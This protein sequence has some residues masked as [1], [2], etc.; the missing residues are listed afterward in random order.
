M[1]KIISLAALTAL[2]AACTETM[3]P[4][5]E[6]GSD[7]LGEEDLLAEQSL[8]DVY[9]LAPAPYYFVGDPY[10]IEGV[11]YVPM[12]DLNYNETGLAGVIP[13]EVNGEKT[14]DGEIYDSTQFVA[15]SKT[16]PLPT[17][18]QVTNLENGKSVV[19]RVNNRGPR[20]NSRIMDLSTAAAARIGLTN[21]ARVQ[22]RVL[23]EQSVAVKNATMGLA[24]PQKVAVNETV[25]VKET[26]ETTPV[27][28]SGDYTVQVDAFI[29][30]DR[31]NVL[32]QRL[33]KYG[34]P[35]IVKE[36]ELFKVRFINLDAAS[37]R[38]LINTL[39][40]SEG[41]KP[42]LLR[43]GSWINPNSI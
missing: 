4:K 32:S 5:G 21:Q 12:E 19:V 30:E 10:K 43:N 41:L 26:V 28:T 23:P 13:N 27:V 15:A 24:Q 36:G 9:L 2:L 3:A 20:L 22:V 40:D 17:I 34:E 37:A 16:L 33:K 39:H 35:V 7:G 38:N 31:A 11:R 42:G 25:E 1:K 29:A 14:S 8:N 18:A 6:Y